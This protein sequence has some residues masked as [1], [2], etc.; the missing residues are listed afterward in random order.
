[1]SLPIF[2]TLEA[3]IA[4]LASVLL[5]NCITSAEVSLLATMIHFGVR[6]GAIP[7]DLIKLLELESERCPLVS[8][9]RRKPGN[10]SSCGLV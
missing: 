5:S 2:F 6:G 1:V 3:E 7:R 4:V 10:I 8:I 9:H